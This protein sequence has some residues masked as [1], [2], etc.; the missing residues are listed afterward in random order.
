MDY[1]K[2]Q[3]LISSSGLN[4]AM[5]IGLSVTFGAIFFGVIAF[6][7]YKKTKS[8][9]YDENNNEIIDPDKRKER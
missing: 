1:Y 3:T 6:T 9:W 7:I 4:L 2:E 5:V 8:G